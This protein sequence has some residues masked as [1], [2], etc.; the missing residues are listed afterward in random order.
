MLAGKEPGIDK[1]SRLADELGVSAS[2]L[3]TGVELTADH[4]KTLRLL[5]RLSPER[6]RLVLD[7]IAE[8]GEAPVS[9]SVDKSGI[10]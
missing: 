3:V 10:V 2:Y 1:V 9:G 7:L 6:R 4:E 5:D 8:L